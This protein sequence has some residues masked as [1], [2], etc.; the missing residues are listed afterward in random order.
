MGFRA[1]RGPDEIRSSPASPRGLRSP[2]VRSPEVRSP[3][4]SLYEP[5]LSEFG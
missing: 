1:E 4:P 5:G 2:E 3:K